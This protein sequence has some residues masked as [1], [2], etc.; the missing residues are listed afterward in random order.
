[1]NQRPLLTF[2]VS[3]YNHETFIREAVEGALAQTYSPLEIV[4]ADDCSTDRSF[5]V[6]RDC[7]AAYRG[8]HTVRVNRNETN[9]GIGG[10]VNRAME[11]S[12]GELIVIAAGD[13]V[14]LPARTEKL[15][16][17]WV[18]SGRR[19]T[20]ICSSYTTISEDG[21]PQGLGG[22]RGDPRDTRPVIRLEADLGSFLETRGPTAPGCTHAWSPELFKYFGPLKSGLEDLVLSFRSM[23]IG[24]ILYLRE[25]LVKYRRHGRNV[26]FFAGGDDCTSFAHREERLRWVDE[27]SANAYANMLADVEVL[28][29]NGRLTAAERDRLRNLGGR[30]RMFYVAEQQMMDRSFLKR[31]KT[32]AGAAGRGDLRCALRLSPRLLPRAL[33]RSLYLLKNRNKAAKTITS[34]SARNGN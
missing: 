10:N 11:L 16:E 29:R 1:M 28:H 31:M 21:T 22:L 7:V 34:G 9:L 30:I 18:Q 20:S 15:C 2:I 8:P 26:S 5:D 23:A 12:H 33:Y 6:I 32:L 13:D 3:C 24:Q 27:Q 25:P 14:S 17:A 4:V 19:A